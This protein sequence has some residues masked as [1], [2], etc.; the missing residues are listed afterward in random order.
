MAKMVSRRELELGI[1]KH[2]ARALRSRHLLD[3][4]PIPGAMPAMQVC[5]NK[6][7]D[8]RESGMGRD[9]KVVFKGLLYNHLYGNHR[10]HVLAHI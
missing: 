8:L 5:H 10:N 9:I 3:C 6:P 2:V 7:Q 4:H 1:C